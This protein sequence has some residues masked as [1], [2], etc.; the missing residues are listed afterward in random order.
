V[1]YT[2]RLHY[3]RSYTA[4][5]DARTCARTALVWSETRNWGLSALAD[6][7]SL[8]KSHVRISV[9]HRSP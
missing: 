3:G 2:F 9:T 8:R 7:Q 6:T 5:L 4:T 1:G